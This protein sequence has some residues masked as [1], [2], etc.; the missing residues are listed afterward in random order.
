MSDPAGWYPDPTTRHELRYWDGYTWL[1]NVSNKGVAASDPLGGKPMPAPSEAA[2][3]A[4]APPPAAAASK[5]PLYVGIGVGVVVIVAVVAFLLTRDSGGGGN[6][7]KTTALGNS[8][9]TLKEK[10]DDP[11]HPT[12]FPVK[13][14]DNSVI[15]IDVKATDTKVTAGI[16]VEAKQSVIDSL[17]AKVSGISDLLENKLKNACGNLR[18]EDLGAK[19]DV[20]YFFT[21]A[22]DVGADLHTFTVV[23]IGGDFEFIPV[24]VDDQG[25]CKGGE[26]EM[27]L[28]PHF[29][30]F[31]KVSNRD[32]LES[33]LADDPK[34]QDF[35]SS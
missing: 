12:V 27:T 5:T 32:D 35:L 23:P 1:D 4:S 13:V 8:A 10:G 20:A 33:T 19:G 31:S 25:T 30:D 17:N 18:E 15:V 9:V 21:P 28:T 24:V 16:I 26:M 3:K 22:D 11:N 2:A 14:A 29:L 6:A 7:E 34:L